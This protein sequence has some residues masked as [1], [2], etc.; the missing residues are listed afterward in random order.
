MSHYRVVVIN[1]DVSTFYE[2]QFPYLNS[3]GNGL[4]TFQLLKPRT[5]E[6]TALQSGNSRNLYKTETTWKITYRK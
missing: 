1:C 6:V 4:P 2:F 3:Q 5:F